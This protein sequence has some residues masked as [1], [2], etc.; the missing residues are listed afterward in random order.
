VWDTDLIEAI[1]P[2]F[3]FTSADASESNVVQTQ[4]MFIEGK[5]VGPIR[6]LVK[7]HER[8]TN[9]PDHVTKGAGVLVQYRFRVE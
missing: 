9:L 3:E 7:A 4:P 5:V 6:K 2:L 1:P 8:S